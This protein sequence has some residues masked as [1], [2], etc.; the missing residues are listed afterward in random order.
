MK[1]WT[2]Q[3][4]IALIKSG[5]ER[6]DFDYK[7]D[8]DL[9]AG[10][11]EKAEIAKDIIAMANSGGGLIAGGVKETPAGF[12][13]EGMSRAVLKAFDSTALNDFVNNYC[14]PPI[15]TT[16]RKMEIDD[17][18]Y[19]VIIVPGF[20]E[21]PHIVVKDYPEVL[22]RGDLLVRSASNNS[23]RA[24]PEDMRKLISLAVR[25]RQ[26][27]LKDLLQAALETRPALVGAAASSAE[28]IEAPFDRSDYAERYKGFRV[29]TIA[30]D[31]AQ[32]TVRPMMLR[33]AAAA[34]VVTDSRSGYPS[35]PPTYFP[36]PLRNDCR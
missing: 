7:A 15:N 34:A 31:E 16:T 18:V 9:T 3:D 21:Q 8:I 2:E 5:E 4:I 10:K 17:K 14:G 30:P 27:A 33:E 29:V 23:V 13:W 25:R 26:G 20:A 24:G 1:I 22:R 19:G 12:L 11:R 35:F 28:F 32:V 36:Q 6:P